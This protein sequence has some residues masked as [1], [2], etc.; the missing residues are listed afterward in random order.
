MVEWEIK[1]QELANCNCSYGCPCQF[2]ARPTDDTC[3]AAVGYEVQ[4]GHYGEVSLDGLRA[5]A[6]YKWPGAVH[7]GNGEMQLIIDESTDEEQRR[8]RRS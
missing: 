2:N 5:A 1:G 7:E 4:E 3:E 8:A 6:V